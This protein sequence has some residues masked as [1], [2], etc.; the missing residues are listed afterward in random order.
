MCECNSP[1]RSG[2]MGY[3]LCARICYSSTM[4][5]RSFRPSA[6]I[7]YLNKV[8]E[9]QKRSED[10]RHICRFVR[11]AR[12]QFGPIIGKIVRTGGRR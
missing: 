11:Y 1:I 8:I 3:G 6:S 10:V 7:Q 5:D 9:K 2:D 12:K 4:S